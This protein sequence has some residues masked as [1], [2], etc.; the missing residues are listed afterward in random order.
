[1]SKVVVSKKLCQN[2][3]KLSPFKEELKQSRKTYVKY[4]SRQLNEEASSTCRM[5]QGDVKLFPY[6]IQMQQALR[7]VDK[8]GRVDFYGDFKMFL[9]DNP[10]VSR[11]IWFSDEAHFHMNG[12]VNKR[13]RRPW[14]SEH[15]HI[16]KE[17]PLR[18]GKGTVR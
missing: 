10:A 16:I 17:T 4:L 7:E 8:A 3:R 15:P 5:I 6:K 1:M 14:A 2:N 12:Y 11:S 13:N 9:E 18:P